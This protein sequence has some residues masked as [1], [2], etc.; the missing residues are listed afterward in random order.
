MIEPHEMHAAM[1]HCIEHEL[2]PVLLSG[3]GKFIVDLDPQMPK[4]AVDRAWSYH[5]TQPRIGIDLLRSNCVA[6]TTRIGSGDATIAALE[7]K[8]GRIA[9][10]IEQSRF[11]QDGRT[12]TGRHV[13]TVRT[14]RWPQAEALHKGDI[15][16][17]EIFFT[18]LGYAPLTMLIAI[19][20]LSEKWTA[21]VVGIPKMQ[22]ARAQAERE[23]ELAWR[24]GTHPSQRPNP[25]SKRLLESFKI[26]HGG[27]LLDLV[28]GQLI[29][30]PSL[31]GA[32]TGSGAL[33][34]ELADMPR[35]RKLQRG[36]AR[37]RSPFKAAMGVG[38]W[39]SYREGDLLTAVTLGDVDELRRAGAILDFGGDVIARNPEFFPPKPP[40]GG[41]RAAA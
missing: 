38:G 28:A 32:L 11:E 24:N 34:G 7:L 36:E 40:H 31:L 13:R 16:D 17:G 39:R 20:P 41:R 6:I 35:A 19:E 27:T 21:H 14:A 12:A 26:Q 5:R 4:E 1:A 9:S 15:C 18:L 29:D 8:L 23:A 10:S 25:N 3:D 37:F 30:D 33:I 22:A 2:S